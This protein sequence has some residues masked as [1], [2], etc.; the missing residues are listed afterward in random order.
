MAKNKTNKKPNPVGRPPLFKTPEKLEAKIKLY[1]ENCPDKR[2]VPT[3]FGG[4][5]ELPS[6]T[7][8][9]LALF[10]GFC[11]RHSMWDYEF[12][13]PEFSNTIKRARAKITQYYENN[14]TGGQCTGPLFMLKNLGYSDQTEV[15]VT[16]GELS[17]AEITSRYNK[18]KGN[19]K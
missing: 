16:E 6:P 19:G 7:I 18:I 8:S 2:Q 15:K 13:R 17:D 1:F 3:A 5:A 14:M 9:G 11:D 10:L 12:G 4:V